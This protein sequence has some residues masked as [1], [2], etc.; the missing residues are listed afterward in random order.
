MIWGKLKTRLFL[1]HRFGE[2]NSAV[3]VFQVRKLEL[4]GDSNDNGLDLTGIDSKGKWKELVKIF[5]SK[6]PSKRFL[7]TIKGYDFIEGPMVE[8]PTLLPNKGLL[9]RKSRRRY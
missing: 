8:L 7:R 2:N 1:W 4:R 5:L 3:L 6:K 9:K